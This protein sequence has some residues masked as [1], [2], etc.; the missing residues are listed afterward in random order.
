[1]IVGLVPVFTG[2]VAQASSLAS[3]SGQTVQ[4][5]NNSSQTI[6]VP[7]APGLIPSSISGSI[8]APQSLNGAP[9]AGGSVVVTA[10]GQRIFQ[11]RAQAAQFTARLK[12]PKVVAGFLPVV[13]RYVVKRLRRSFCTSNVQQLSAN[14]SSLSFVGV[15]ESPN[16]VADFLV[17]G[18]SG[19]NVVL[20]KNPTS[21]QVQ[22]GLVAVGSVAYKLGPLTQVRLS[23]GAR[24]SRIVARPGARVIQFS[25]SDL[26]VAVTVAETD[27][28]PQL[29][30]SGNGP[31]LSEAATALGGDKLVLADGSPVTKLAQVTRP[32]IN[33]NQ[34]FAQLGQPKP[35][36]KGWGSQAISLN[37]NQGQFGSSISDARVRLV[38]ATTQIPDGA[39]AS[40]NVY[41]NESLIGSTNLQDSPGIDTEIPVPNSLLRTNN[42]VQIELATL[43]AGGR[44]TGA[45]IATP[46]G[47]SLDPQLS[48]IMANR[49][50]TLSPGFGRLPQTLGGS[51]PISFAQGEPTPV[52]VESAALL[53]AAL[54]WSNSPQLVVSV[55]PYSQVESGPESTLVLDANDAVSAKLGAPLTLNRSREISS[56]NLDFSATTK[57]PYSALQ[58]FSSGTRNMLLLGGWAPTRATEL[59][60]ASSSSG[61][62]TNS[63]GN[64]NSVSA[65]STPSTP[66]APSATVQ[67]SSLELAEY[68]YAQ[69]A[70][71]SWLTGD[72]AITESGSQ[73]KT[74][75]SNAAVPQPAITQVDRSAFWWM[76][77]II[78]IFVGLA[79]WRYAYVRHQRGDSPNSG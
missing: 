59:D 38:G 50:Q 48:Q 53:V 13:V 33:L 45:E 49:G 74:L 52:A 62:S 79:S 57:T 68:I 4:V 75:N 39:Q 67:A 73:P 20:P 32:T 24:D 37:V 76:I 35:Q 9:L 51:L 43:P 41:W 1:M 46:I 27:G 18:V 7:V 58:A 72:I 23:Q 11:G 63:G 15:Q 17:P 25:T 12:Q 30:I 66:S 65:P 8:S 26:P 69:P 42:T 36:F 40:I 60:I 56:P 21:A 64:E 77:G 2:S 44:C 29:T 55:L 70:G 54:Q 61:T 10:G 34:S 78:V 19:V 28:L 14:I 3:N 6:Q 5:A 31:E 71:W 16:S 47:V 22:A